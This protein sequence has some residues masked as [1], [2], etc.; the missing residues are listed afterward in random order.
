MDKQTRIEVVY[1]YQPIRNEPPNY[2]LVMDKP[3]IPY[4]GAILDFITH[5]LIWYPGWI[6]LALYVLSRVK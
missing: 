4:I 5:P 2:V 1:G 6:S 3:R